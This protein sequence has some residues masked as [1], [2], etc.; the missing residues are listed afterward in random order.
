[1]GFGGQ[2]AYTFL[3]AR[4]T[5]ALRPRP[6]EEVKAPFWRRAMQSKYS[7]VKHLSHEEYKQVLEDKLLR[8]D[9]EIAVLDDDIAALRREEAVGGIVK[10]EETK[11]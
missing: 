2:R 3:D 1:M 5:E 10:T 4:N 9:A 7:P 6:A 11:S 8:V